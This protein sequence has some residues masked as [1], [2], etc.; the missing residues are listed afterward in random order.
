MGLVSAALEESPENRESY[1][2][3]ACGTDP[4]LYA[5]VEERILWEERMEGFLT[6]ILIETLELLDRPFE[7]G[8]LVAGRFRVL[9]EVGRGE[10]G[11]EPEK[12]C[13]V[14]SR[15]VMEPG[16]AAHR[17][18]GESGHAPGAR[19]RAAPRGWRGT[20]GPGVA[21]ELCKG[22]GQCHV[23]GGGNVN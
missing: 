4:E 11:T 1:L 2:R 8:E 6:Q 15:G 21:F 18:R 10:F 7:P 22:A 3:S 17:S 12:L 20:G 23:C 19:V 5:E 13:P 16:E 14:R 9:N